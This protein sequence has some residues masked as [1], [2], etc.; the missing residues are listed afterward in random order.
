MPVELGW[1][2]RRVL[3]IAGG[4][5]VLLVLAAFVLMPNVESGPDL[6]TTYSA[7]SGGAKAAWLLLGELGYDARRWERPPADLPTRADRAVL[8]L[9]DPTT[10]PREADIELVRD[11]ARR[12]GRVIVTGALAATFFPDEAF[13]VNRLPTVWRQ[14][15]AVN[16]SAITRAAPR[17]TLTPS[18][19]WA[20]RANGTPLF[21]DEAGTRVIE[22]QEG[23]GT[24][25]LW[26]SAT[27]LTNAGL[28]EPGN[29]EFFL[30]CLGAPGD[31]QV[32][33]DEYFHGYRH[34]LTASAI[35][36]PIAWLLLHLGFIAVAVLWTYSRRSGPVFAP[37]TGSRLSPLE[38]VRTL[39]HLYERAG[40]AS[41]A[42]DVT[43]SRFRYLL[44][45]RLGVPP[46]AP[47]D[48]LDAGLA[49]RHWAVDPNLRATLEACEAARS[50]DDLKPGAA[51]RLVRALYRHGTALRLFDRDLG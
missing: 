33:W 26:A 43:Y 25:V 23:K 18:A 11:F 31:V 6:P 35:N 48:V 7:A 5:F 21:A 42:V 4:A 50:R 32:L 14:V 16:L 34:S 22:R 10:Y 38:F 19:V 29:V 28:K 40:A 24:V 17:I 9:A 49:E 27:P 36:S 44:T 1:A 20:A 13:T 8:I 47:P 12:G 37:V 30:A 3:T 39:G 2:D 15:P 41:T 46:D 51:L 45:R